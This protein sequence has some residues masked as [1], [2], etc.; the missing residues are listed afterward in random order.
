MPAVAVGLEDGAGLTF[1]EVDA[2]D[3]AVLV[4]DVDLALEVAEAD[5]PEDALHARLEVALGWR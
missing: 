3:P 2:S 4:A 1:E 5:I